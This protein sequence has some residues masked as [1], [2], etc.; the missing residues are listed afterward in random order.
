MIR[1]SLPFWCNF[2]ILDGLSE[3]GDDLLGSPRAL[4]E[5]GVIQTPVY[6]ILPPSQRYWW[7]QLDNACTLGGSFWYITFPEE[8]KK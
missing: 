7:A 3:Q 6:T 4:Y 8:N 2:T 5:E 1:L